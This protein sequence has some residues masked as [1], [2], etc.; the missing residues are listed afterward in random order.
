MFVKMLIFV[1]FTLTLSLALGFSQGGASDRE[2]KKEKKGICE[3]PKTDEDR[4]I[5]VR[6]LELQSK[7][8]LEKAKTLKNQIATPLE[9]K[10]I[11]Q[12]SKEE[13]LRKKMEEDEAEGIEKANVTGCPDVK[14]NPKATGT[15]SWQPYARVMIVNTENIPINILSPEFGEV[16]T[17]LCPGKSVTL[18]RRRNPFLDGNTIQYNYKAVGYFADGSLG[19]AESPYVSLSA[20]QA[21]YQ[22]GQFLTWQVRLEKHP[23]RY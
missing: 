1:L 12:L 3:D 9:A 4:L 6:A 16:V 13:K 19:T 8:D 18:F 17:H 10:A 14:V 23:Q 22:L 2:S 5:C 15:R 11:K 20:Y 21:D 7:Q